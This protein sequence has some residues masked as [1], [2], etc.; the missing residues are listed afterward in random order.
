M[1]MWISSAARVLGGWFAMR[2]YPA[3]SYGQAKS[4]SGVSAFPV[5]RGSC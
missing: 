4:A 1:G 2:M 5:F 3:A